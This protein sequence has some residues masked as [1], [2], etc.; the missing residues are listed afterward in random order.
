M[1]NSAH[2]TLQ[3]ESSQCW[4]EISVIEETRIESVEAERQMESNTNIST[5]KKVSGDQD[6]DASLIESLCIQHSPRLHQMTANMDSKVILYAIL[7]LET[8]RQWHQFRC[9]SAFLLPQS[10]LNTDYRIHAH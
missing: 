4:R 3:L 9:Y 1:S 8:L 10:T 2:P 5:F 6:G 7:L